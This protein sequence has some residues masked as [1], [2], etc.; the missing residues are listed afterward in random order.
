MIEKRSIWEMILSRVNFAD[1]GKGWYSGKCQLCGDYKVRAGFKLTDGVITYNCWNCATATK[2]VEYSQEMSN[3]FKEVLRAYG[4][5]NAEISA[6]VASAFFNKE[7]V[8][9]MSLAA[10]TGKSD[11]IITET[12]EIKLPF[13][14]KRIV[15]GIDGAE[16]FIQYLKKR[17]INYHRYPFFFTNDAEYLRDRLIIPFYRQN[18]LIYWQGRR[19][20]G[21]KKKRYVNANTVA[22]AVMFNMDALT[23][24]SDF[25]LFVTEGALDAVCFGGLGLMHGGAANANKTHFLKQ[26]KRKL[27]FV[28]DKNDVGAKTAYYALENGWDITF[29]PD[30]S[31]DINDSVIKYGKMW[32]AMEL[33]KAIPKDRNQ[34]LLRVKLYCGAK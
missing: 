14:C 13:G 1:N 16:P 28:I 22:D 5:S 24:H 15:E 30:G 26:T 17:K 6:A 34:A 8:E 31:S 12:P 25:P 7:P 21:E 11:K 18:K 2:Y 4:F 3:K 20:D 10:L 23:A 32:T 29:A 27:I 33:V 9:E 19:I